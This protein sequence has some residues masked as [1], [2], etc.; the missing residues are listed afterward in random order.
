MH[1][2]GNSASPTSL[3][4]SENTVRLYR[5]A[6]HTER[7]FHV[8]PWLAEGFGAGAAGGRFV[9]DA[10][11]GADVGAGVPDGGA[12]GAG[13]QGSLTGLFGRGEITLSEKEAREAQVRQWLEGRPRGR[14]A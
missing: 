7:D 5:G 9:R 11:G 14:F 6:R 13:G 12:V 8:L 3:A 1:L 4:S 2:A 10:A